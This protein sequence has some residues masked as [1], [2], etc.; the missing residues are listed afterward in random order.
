MRER[1]AGELYGVHT[2]PA[3]DHDR[4]D[5]DR[6]FDEGQNWLVALETSAVENGP[7]P[8][9]E[10]DDIV[11]DEDVLRPPHASDRRDTPV[12]DHGAGGRRGL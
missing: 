2:P 8:E 3:V 12:A 11:D 6:A 9:R 10:L 1:D 4:P 5:D 7:E